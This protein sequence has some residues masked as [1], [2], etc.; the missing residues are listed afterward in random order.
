MP[1]TSAPAPRDREEERSIA[2]YIV[3][4]AVIDCVLSS[5]FTL[6]TID[7]SRFRYPERSIVFLFVCYLAVGLAYVV[8][9]AIGP[10]IACGG[11][12]T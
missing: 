5:L 7:P 10:R 1:A 2:R 11:E 6:L 3:G 12:E 4:F 8:G 9:F